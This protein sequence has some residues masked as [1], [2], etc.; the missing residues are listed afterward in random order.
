MERKEEWWG[1][2]RSYCKE[3]RKMMGEKGEQV[4]GTERLA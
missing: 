2:K 1:R 4:E 3:K